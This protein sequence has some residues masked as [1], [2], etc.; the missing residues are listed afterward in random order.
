MRRWRRWLILVIGTAS[1][2]LAVRYGYKAVHN[3]AELVKYSRRLRPGLTRKEVKDYLRGQG[4]EFK[5][6]CCYESFHAFAVIVKTGDEFAPWFCSEWPVY[7][8]FE[9]AVTKPYNLPLPVDP[10]ILNNI[11]RYN[12]ELFPGDS[13]VLKKVHLVSN[14]EGCL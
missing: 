4:T 3:H 13:D 14:G 8:A 11:Q 6:R 10:K 7:V 1:L 12:L 2:A 5:E 9:F